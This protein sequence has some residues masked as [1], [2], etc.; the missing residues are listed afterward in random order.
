MRGSKQYA[1]KNLNAVAA[2]PNAPV[3]TLSKTTTTG[4]GST[5]NNSRI[6]LTHC[7]LSFICLC[8][9]KRE[10]DGF[11]RNNKSK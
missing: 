1:N 3:S 11:T 9:I 10:F 4:N 8:S 5:L 2:R 6:F 7:C